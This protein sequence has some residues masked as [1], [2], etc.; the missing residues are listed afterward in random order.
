MV[1]NMKL[2]EKLLRVLTILSVISGVI[3]CFLLAWSFF[4][5]FEKYSTSSTTPGWAAAFFTTFIVL[6]I[7]LATR[8]KVQHAI[9]K[10][11]DPN[12]LRSTIEHARR[13]PTNIV[14]NAII[15]IIVVAITL[16]TL[17]FF[18]L[19]LYWK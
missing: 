12:E 13:T 19:L 4:I 17:F 1:S 11:A 6:R 3:F 9:N 15:S 5:G 18:A 8:G 16:S 2:N 7:K 10:S 14:A